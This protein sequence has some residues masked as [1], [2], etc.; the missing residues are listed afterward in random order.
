MAGKLGAAPV[1]SPDCHCL[2]LRQAA[3]RVTRFYDDVL[4]P[5]GLRTSQFSILARLHRLGPMPINTLAAVLALDRTTLGRNLL[6][7]RRQGLI[8]ASRRG[9]DRRSKP[10]E[11]TRAGVARLKAAAQLWGEAQARFEA[12][13]GVSRLHALRALLDEVTR[14]GPRLA[15]DEGV[16]TAKLSGERALRRS[17]GP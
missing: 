12:V 17:T 9:K 15:R 14:A 13:F 2:A 10:V 16:K 6:P 5:A 8:E 4:A 7:L 1:G 3:R 11:V